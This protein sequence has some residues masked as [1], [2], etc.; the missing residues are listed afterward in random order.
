MYRKGMGLFLFCDTCV[1]RSEINDERLARGIPAVETQ[2]IQ[3][4]ADNTRFRQQVPNH[5]Q[6]Q[7]TATFHWLATVIE[8]TVCTTSELINR[9]QHPRVFKIS[10]HQAMALRRSLERT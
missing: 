7:Q 4:E 3:L 10:H 1:A 8:L 9:R 2:A 6:R 5:S